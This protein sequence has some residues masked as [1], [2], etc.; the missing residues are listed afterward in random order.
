MIILAASLVCSSMWAQKLASETASV[1]AADADCETVIVPA[2]YKGF[3]TPQNSPTDGI[4][5]KR[6]AGTLCYGMS[7]YHTTQN[8]G[9]R[10]ATNALIMLP[11]HT[12]V[13]FKNMSTSPAN[14]NWSFN[15]K[16][17]KPKAIPYKSVE[18]KDNNAYVTTGGKSAYPLPVLQ[19]AIRAYEW[20]EDTPL[21]ASYP[22]MCYIDSVV[23]MSYE[24]I[25]FQ[26][27]IYNTDGSNYIVGPRADRIDFNQD[28]KKET[29]YMDGF[30]IFFPKPIA[31]LS[32]SRVN[33]PITSNSGTFFE[34]DSKLTFTIYKVKNTAMGKAYGDVIFTTEVDS[35]F[36]P[37]PSGSLITG[38]QA[39]FTIYMKP[40]KESYITIDEEFAIEF[41]G[42]QRPG[43]D[44]GPRV[45]PRYA[46]AQSSPDVV[47]LMYRDYVDKEGNYVGSGAYTNNLYGIPISFYGAYDVVRVSP[48][49]SVVKVSADGQSCSSAASVVTQ[50]SWANAAGKALYTLVDAP[51]WVK[52]VNAKMVERNLY[53]VAVV[54]DPLPAGVESRSCTVKVKSFMGAESKTAI[55]I[56]QGGAGL[57]G[58]VNGDGKVDVAD[59]NIIIDIILGNATVD[60]YPAAD[61]TG[62]G[63]VDVADVNA[64]IDIILAA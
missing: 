31:P 14:T 59:V 45:S 26:T 42:F 48:E 30:H 20:C 37:Q 12:T 23:D 25:P 43:I 17:A 11:V 3:A 8:S 29:V 7:N 54:C 27:M 6:P 49:A 46:G 22:S 64:V 5:Y 13:E 63:K 53:D 60:Q 9:W 21:F 56:T 47:P 62:D 41:K 32:F 28:G 57:T 58:D 50:V 39:H 61:V 24:E 51:E 34:S 55:T 2:G 4:W 33:F 1:N 38:R 44:L 36:F 16:D 35:T 18:I 10:L 15:V 40:D 52:S 19:N